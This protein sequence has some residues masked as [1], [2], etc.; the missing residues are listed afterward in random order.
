MKTGLPKAKITLNNWY[1]CSG[2][3]ATIYFGTTERAGKQV[4]IALKRFKKERFVIDQKNNILKPE[5][6]FEEYS[7]MKALLAVEIIQAV[8]KLGV[9]TLE[10]FKAVEFEGEGCIL[11]S[12]ACMNGKM[13]WDGL[14]YANMMGG[15]KGKPLATMTSELALLHLLN[16]K[17]GQI[18][19]CDK[20][21]R[22]PTP[23]LWLTLENPFHAVMADVT[24]LQIYPNPEIQTDILD[25]AD[26]ARVD[27]GKMRDEYEKAR[28][29]WIEQIMQQGLEPFHVENS[30]SVII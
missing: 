20:M 8:A 11:M 29:I 1:T 4:R 19:E 9:P 2:K 16:L 27:A 28:G 15:I 23:T 21:M 10:I 17:L 22:H 5:L 26:L 14:R 13:P 18:Y 3:E 30:N 25:L 12:D 24:N 6:T 7:T